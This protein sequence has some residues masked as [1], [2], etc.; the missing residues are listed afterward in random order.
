LPFQ[1]NFLKKL[2]ILI[3]DLEK[4]IKNVVNDD[5][6]PLMSET[7]TITKELAEVSEK[8]NSLVNGGEKK[9][10]GQKVY[11]ALIPKYFKENFPALKNFQNKTNTKI[12]ELGK[13]RAVSF[14]KKNTENFQ[15]IS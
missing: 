10:E 8:I 12:K 14:I 5:L 15:K 7:F 13:T 3:S 9:S 11:Q 6:K 4:E 1:V 2:I